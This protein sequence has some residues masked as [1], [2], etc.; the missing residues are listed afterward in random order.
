MEI[1]YQASNALSI[2]L[3]LYYGLTCLFTETRVAEFERFGLGP[4]R[5]LTGSLEVLGAL[6]LLAGYLVPWLAIVASGGLSLLMVLG[7]TTRIRVRDSLWEMLPALVL[8]LVN[9]YILAYAVGL[10]ASP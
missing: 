4:F 3:F 1:A 2:A 10:A 7:V 8:M 9:L 5:R 6:G